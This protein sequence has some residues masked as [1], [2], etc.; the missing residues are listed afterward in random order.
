[1]PRAPRGALACRK[2]FDIH[3]ITEYTVEPMVPMLP[4]LPAPFLSSRRAAD[5]LLYHRDLDAGCFRR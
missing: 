1:M 3:M 2:V 5:N 4:P